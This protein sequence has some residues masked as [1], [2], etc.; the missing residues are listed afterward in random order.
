[1]LKAMD[2]ELRAMMRPV[3]SKK[4]KAK[5]TMMMKMMMSER[6]AAVKRT[7]E[8]S[9]DMKFKTNA[10]SIKSFSIPSIECMISVIK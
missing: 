1:M 10:K 5:M 4:M 8:L 6:S 7:L 2:L 9:E 3:S